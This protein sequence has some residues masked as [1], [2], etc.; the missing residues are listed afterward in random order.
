MHSGGRY[1]LLVFVPLAS[2]ALVE[3]TAKFYEP[4]SSLGLQ[5]LAYWPI[6]CALPILSVVSFAA[7]GWWEAHVKQENTILYALS[8]AALGVLWYIAAFLLIGSLHIALGG[9]L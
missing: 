7:L 2:L 6:P 8:G 1:L 5:L 4:E 3:V 9:R